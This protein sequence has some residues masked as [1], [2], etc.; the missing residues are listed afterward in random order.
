MSTNRKLKW[1]N[2]L[3]HEVQC[4]PQATGCAAFRLRDNFLKQITGTLIIHSISA[5][6]ANLMNDERATVSGDTELPCV[7]RSL[8]PI[9]LNGHSGF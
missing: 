1:P 9:E 6:G 7:T 8:K 5:G 2:G 4:V 3:L